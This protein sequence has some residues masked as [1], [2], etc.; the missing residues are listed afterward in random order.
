MGENTVHL[1]VSKYIVAVHAV[2]FVTEYIVYICLCTLR[3]K[4]LVL[5]TLKIK[6]L[7]YY[8]F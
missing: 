8:K 4:A 7:V 2:S 6:A 3:I 5:Y 1:F